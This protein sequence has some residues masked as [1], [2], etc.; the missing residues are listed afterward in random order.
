MLYVM[1]DWGFPGCL[2]D[3]REVIGDYESRE[4]ALRAGAEYVGHTCG[5]TYGESFDVEALADALTNRVAE[6]LSDDRWQGFRIADP[7]NEYARFDVHLLTED[8]YAAL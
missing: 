6:C 5:H 1:V 4:D 2:P 7:V 3:D 8:Q